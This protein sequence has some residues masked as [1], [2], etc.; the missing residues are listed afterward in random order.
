MVKYDGGVKR[1]IA[2][3]ALLQTHVDLLLQ[4]GVI[5][6]T[7]AEKV[8]A[9]VKPFVVEEIEKMR[10]RFICEP[11][12]NVLTLSKPSEEMLDLCTAQDLME[13]ETEGVIQDDFP[14]FYGQF[15]IPE[16]KRDYYCFTFKGTWYRLIK[17]PTGGR[18]EPNMAHALTASLTLHAH[19]GASLLGHRTKHNSFVD[20]ARFHGSETSSTAAMEIFRRLAKD[21]GITISTETPKWCTSYVFLGIQIDHK[22]K[23]VSLAEKTVRKLG[24][25]RENLEEIPEETTLKNLLSFLGLMVWSA[26]IL[27]QIK[28]SWYPLL[29]FTRRRIRCYSMKDTVNWWPIA[30]RTAKMIVASLIENEARCCAHNTKEV[31][32]FTDASKTGWGVVIFAAD[33]YRS[34][35]RRLESR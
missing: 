21:A 3:A 18:A 6:R 17:V 24:I 15:E 16:D 8:V 30:L 23:T 32:A 29:K 11:H 35:G 27:G 4:E 12:T 22:T 28:S 25:V 5:E 19:E 34:F 26:S 9:T 1:H 14:W 13:V 10:L 2:E 20:N 31:T 7:T 33:E